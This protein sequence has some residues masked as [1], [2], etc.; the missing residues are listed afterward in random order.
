MHLQHTDI[1]LYIS[2]LRKVSKP[3]GPQ[4]PGGLEQVSPKAHY[5]AE[6]Q[7]LESLLLAYHDNWLQEGPARVERE[8]VDT[9]Y[10]PCLLGSLRAQH[11]HVG[12]PPMPWLFVHR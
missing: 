7:Q 10:Q 12:V 3:T 6:A 4:D 9:C 8:I 5:G 2:G 11:V 1:L